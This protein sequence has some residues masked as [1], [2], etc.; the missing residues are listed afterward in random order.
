M[1]VD[2]YSLLTKAVAGKD[3]IARD[4]IYRDAHRLIERSDLAREAAA[5]GTN[6][7]D[8]FHRLYRLWFALGVPAFGAVLAIVWLM[9]ARPAIALG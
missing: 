1:T 4:R 3:T 5:A 7:P 2:Y 6:L 9:L 8:R